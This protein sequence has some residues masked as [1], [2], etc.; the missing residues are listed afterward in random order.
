[1]TTYIVEEDSDNAYWTLSSSAEEEEDEEPNGNNSTL[2]RQ[3]DESD[4]YY[5]DD[6]DADTYWAAHKW[7]YNGDVDWEQYYA[8]VAREETIATFLEE[9]SDWLA[10]SDE[11]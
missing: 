2:Q 11:E 7:A 4:D 8:E 10:Y 6:W 1:M 9:N 3:P 5:S